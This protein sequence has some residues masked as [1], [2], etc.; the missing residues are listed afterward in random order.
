[1]TT[2]NTTTYN[3]AMALVAKALR[4]PNGPKRTRAI[5]KALVAGR[6]C[7]LDRT[8]VFSFLGVSPIDSINGA[9]PR[10]YA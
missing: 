3:Q 10:G 7:G 2:N 8:Q 4:L 9:V 1:M 5:E 6:K